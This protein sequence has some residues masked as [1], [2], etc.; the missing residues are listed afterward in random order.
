MGGHISRG[1]VW[2]WFMVD[3]VVFSTRAVADSLNS[4]RLGHPRVRCW[5]IFL[6]F[7]HCD[8]LIID[9]L[10]GALDGWRLW[11]DVVSRVAGENLRLDAQLAPL[12]LSI[13]VQPEFECVL[14]RPER[15]LPYRKLHVDLV[16]NC[17]LV[18]TV[19]V[20]GDY[21]VFMDKVDEWACWTDSWVSLKGLRESAVR[22]DGL[23]SIAPH[24][25]N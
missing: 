7:R 20:Q 5:N 11:T 6:I 10:E 4:D 17:F 3:D 13:V 9:F 24:F 14:S 25:E 18:I 1:R 19:S 23:N 16:L 8:H 2:V 21:R 22:F 12:K 15:N